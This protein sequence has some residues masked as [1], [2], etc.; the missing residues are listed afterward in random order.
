MTH[1]KFLLSLLALVHLFALAAGPLAHAG[2]THGAMQAQAATVA[3]AAMNAASMSE[4]CAGH[5]NHSAR[6]KLSIA[7]A[8]HDAAPADSQHDCCRSTDCQGTCTGAW[9]LPAATLTLAFA[10]AEPLPP[11]AFALDFVARSSEVFRPPIV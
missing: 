11:L 10:R 1:R 2:M 5:G 9:L 7:T 6:D 3:A 8:A 4:D